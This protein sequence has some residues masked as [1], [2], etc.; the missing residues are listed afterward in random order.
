[1]NDKNILK[2]IELLKELLCLRNVV[3][4]LYNNVL[5]I[6]WLSEGLYVIVVKWLKYFYF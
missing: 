4:A 5:H 2:I 6:H 3:V 1:M